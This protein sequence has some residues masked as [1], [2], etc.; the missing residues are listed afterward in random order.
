MHQERN[1]TIVS[2]LLTQIQDFTEQSKFLVRC[3][4]IVRS[5]NSEQFWSDPRFRSNPHCSESQNFVAL[6]F[7]IAAWYTEC[8]GY[9]RTRFWTTTCPRRTNLYY[10]RRF[11][12]FGIFSSFKLGLDADG[13]TNRPELFLT[14]VWSIIRDFRFRNCIWGNFLTLWNF[15]AAKST[16]KLKYVQRQQI[17]ISQCAGSKKLR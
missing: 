11:T 2:Q 5:W 14:V 17:L 4:R 7:K 13:N 3:K 16:S 8:Y 10:L 12:E 15:K 9:I 1:P 6:W